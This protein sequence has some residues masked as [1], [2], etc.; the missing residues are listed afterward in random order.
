MEFERKDLEK[1]IFV[2]GHKGMVGSAITRALKHHG[3]KNVVVRDKADLDLSNQ[4]AVAEYFSNEKFDVVY[5][6][7]AKVGGIHANNTYPADFIYQNLMVE[8]NVIHSSWESNVGKL[9]M[10]GSSCIY[11]KYSEQPISESSLLC[12]RIEPTN[13]PYGVAKIAGIKMC[14]SYRRQYDV[15]YRSAMPT[16]L[17]GLG[18]NYHPENSHVIPALIRRFYEAKVDGLSSVSIWG[19]GTQSREFLFVDDLAE[20]CLF[21]ME[22]DRTEYESV[23]E[24]QQGHINIG[25]G[26][27]I[28]ISSLVDVISQQVGYEGEIYYDTS[29][30][31]GPKRKLIDSSIMLKLGWAPRVLLESGIEICLDEFKSKHVPKSG[32]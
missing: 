13:E 31:D 22:L 2:A 8:T 5:L 14:E 29:K 10:L 7:A 27:D 30:P 15:D 25:Y 24:P 20:A 9:L 12:G 18:D 4:A 23:T 11:P 26:T 1:K 21:L 17:Y 28:T 32:D 6:A 16:N 19:S 3:Y